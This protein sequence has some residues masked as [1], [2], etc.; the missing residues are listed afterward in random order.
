MGLI[1]L[2]FNEPNDGLVATCSTHL[3]K[4]IRDDYRM[5]HLDEING[6]LGIHS[7]LKPIR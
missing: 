5:N 7:C 1:G 4:V 2:V 6:L 3:G